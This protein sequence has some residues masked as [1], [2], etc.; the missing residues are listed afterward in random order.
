VLLVDSH[1]LSDSFRAYELSPEEV[2]EGLAGL[3]PP[4]DCVV[5]LSGTGMPTLDAMSWMQ[6]RIGVPMVSSN[7]ACAF[8]VSRRLGL[9]P[10]AA[11]SA[12]CPALAALLPGPA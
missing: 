2:A 11:L 10:G 3:A 5:L 8:A 7:L 9:G 1:K 6:G 12:C 4:A